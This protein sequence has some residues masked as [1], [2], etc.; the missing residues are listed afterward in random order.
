MDQNLQSNLLQT[1]NQAYQDL[2]CRNLL[3]QDLTLTK[4]QSGLV[5]KWTDKASSK[6]LNDFSGLYS[7]AYV[8]EEPLLNTNLPNYGLNNLNSGFKVA[9]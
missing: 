4:D 8:L 5:S 1:S 3:G 6:I 9:N 7:S 2:I